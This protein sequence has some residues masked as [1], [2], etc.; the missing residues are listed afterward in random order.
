MPKSH[1]ALADQFTTTA[2]KHHR[3]RLD[4][5][6]REHAAAIAA[7]KASE[8]A[9]KAYADQHARKMKKAFSE[10]GRDI[11]PLVD[12][13]RSLPPKKGLEFFVRA[14][15]FLNDRFSHR[16]E[17]K[18][19]NMWLVY[20]EAAPDTPKQN[21]SETHGLFMPKKPWAGKSSPGQAAAW[22]YG[23][24]A[25][26]E[27][28]QSILISERPVLHMQFEQTDGQEALIK[29]HRYTEK[30]YYAPGS[31]QPGSYRGDYARH[32]YIHDKR[33][34]KSLQEFVSLIAAWVAEVA[35]DRI[36]EVRTALEGG[37]KARQ[38]AA[39]PQETVS[40]M[41]PP[42]VRKRTQP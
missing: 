7:Q 19:I 41:R 26:G 32:E 39:A 40:V 29:S 17:R 42:T 9:A 14:D 10:Y 34:H 4:A 21:G 11:A 36:A 2:E 18:S 31:R 5:Q 28:N 23:A 24:E 33:E 12:A 8:K 13:L 27:E 35:P 15:T 16:P 25:S 38:P 1:K 22:P 37:A 6:S 20:S 30:Y 3:Q